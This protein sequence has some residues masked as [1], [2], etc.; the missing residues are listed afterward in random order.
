MRMGKLTS[1][2]QLALADAQSL[3][4]GLDNQL[5]EPVHVM[6]AL[7]DQDGGACPH[8]LARAGVRVN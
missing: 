7:L 2:F 8:L 5:I 4:P 3:A 1:K 6:M